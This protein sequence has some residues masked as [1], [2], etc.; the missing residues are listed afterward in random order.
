MNVYV[1]MSIY[2]VAP[3]LIQNFW[4]LQPTQAGFPQ[5]LMRNQV[6]GFRDAV[7]LSAIPGGRAPLNVHAAP[8]SFEHLGSSFKN[9][10]KV[11][12]LK[13]NLKSKIED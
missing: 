3:P 1:Y 4:P 6:S 10:K 11:S 7:L 5:H 8:K 2:M 12:N 9:F 13:L